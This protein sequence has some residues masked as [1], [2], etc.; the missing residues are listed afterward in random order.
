MRIDRHLESEI[1]EFL[2]VQTVKVPSYWTSPQLRPIATHSIFTDIQV[3]SENLSQSGRVS[4]DSA[5]LGAKKILMR[6]TWWRVLVLR[7]YIGHQWGSRKI[8]DIKLN[9]TFDRN[10]S[11]SSRCINTTHK[12][13]ANFYHFRH[14]FPSLRY[15][16]IRNNFLRDKQIKISLIQ[17]SANG[18]KKYTSPVRY[19]EIFIYRRQ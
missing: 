15:T 19:I 9:I 10:G 12:S 3:V 6:Q 14:S 1:R 5:T 7:I 16:R 8:I 13:H 18:G 11:I 4:S 2:E 17:K